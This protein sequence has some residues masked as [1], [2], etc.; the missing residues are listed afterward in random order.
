LLASLLGEQHQRRQ[1]RGQHAETD[2]GDLEVKV[3]A[4]IRPFGCECSA[5]ILCLEW[6]GGKLRIDDSGFAL[7]CE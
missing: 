5:A 4:H 2:H 1:D 7:R 6:M 3:C